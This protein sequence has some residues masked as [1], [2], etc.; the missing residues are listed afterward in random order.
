MANLILLNGRAVDANLA[1]VTDATAY[2]FAAGSTTPLTVYTD[3][4][5][6]TPRGT[7]VAADASGIFPQCW[8][9]AQDVKVDVR[10]G[11]GNS[12]P[13]FPQ[14]NY[15][16]LP[17]TGSTGTDVTMTPVTGNGGTNAQDF[18]ANNVS[19]LNR[20]DNAAGLPVA[21]GAG[22]SYA[23][24]SPYAITAYA[25]RQE[26]EF[27]AN[28]ANAGGGSDTLNVD[29]VGAAT[30]KK[31][32]GST[33]K[34]DLAAGDFGT[35]DAVRVKYDGTNFIVVQ[36]ILPLSTNT[37]FSQDTGDIASR[38]TTASY[39]A[40]LSTL[41][42]TFVQATY[43]TTQRAIDTA[44]QNTSSKPMFVTCYG[45]ATTN[46]WADFQLSPDGSTGWTTHGQILP[47]TWDA[48]A[49]INL[50]VLPGWYWRYTSATP[51]GSINE[52]TGS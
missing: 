51:A 23:I 41:D 13:G 25:T 43:T 44:Y 37:D 1:V 32:S 33:T 2:F 49:S 8:T 6:G 34:T 24:T 4:G 52:I 15:P 9:S 19:R 35:G 36:T 26:F 31:Y 5:L 14:D 18:G 20:F 11:A 47:S 21:T 45:K 48:G 7:T 46:T 10:N 22:G 3:N 40:G 16:T 30:L 50:L 39:I 29:A 17:E 42:G 27:I 38:G 28:H 12:L